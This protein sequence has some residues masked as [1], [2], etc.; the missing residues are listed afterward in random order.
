MKTFVITLII[1]LTLVGLG[2]FWRDLLPK[3]SD[4]YQVTLFNG[5]FKILGTSVTDKVNLRAFTNLTDGL[6]IYSSPGLTV[7]AEKYTPTVAYGGKDQNGKPYGVLMSWDSKEHK[8]VKGT[9]AYPW[10]GPIPGEQQ[11]KE[12]SK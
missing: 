5:D 6:N 1:T 3:T 7:T 4:P 8:L 9:E 12:E 2:M 11:P 10:N